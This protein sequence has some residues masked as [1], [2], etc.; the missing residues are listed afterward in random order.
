MHRVETLR[1]AL[2]QMRQTHA[3]HLEA[4]LL[5]AR[6]NKTG[7][8]FG[9]GVRLDDGE[10]LFRSHIRTIIAA[11]GLH[12]RHGDSKSYRRRCDPRC[13]ATSRGPTAS[14]E[15]DEGQPVLPGIR[16]RSAWWRARP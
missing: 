13:P 6:Q 8:A 15:V 5:D 3:E 4:G 1:F 2:G 14:A 10:R 9:D 11:P 12:S 16:P 7:H